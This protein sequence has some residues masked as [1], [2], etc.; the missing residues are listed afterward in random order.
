MTPATSLPTDLLGLLFHL[1]RHGWEY[2][3]SSREIS[4]GTRRFTAVVWRPDVLGGGRKC[5][6]E[7]PALALTAALLS[8]RKLRHR[9]QQR[10]KRSTE[11]AA[12][13]TAPGISP[14]TRPVKETSK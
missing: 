7:T 5:R 4:D 8:A 11:L 13:Q 6:H 3:F 2:R 12:R 14:V 1:D 9:R 10:A